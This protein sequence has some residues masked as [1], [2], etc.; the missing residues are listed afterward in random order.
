MD[1]KTP[2]RKLPNVDLNTK[3]QPSTSADHNTINYEA[4]TFFT[5]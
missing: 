3:P 1:I 2:Q 5:C 4:S